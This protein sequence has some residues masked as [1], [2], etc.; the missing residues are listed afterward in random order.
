MVGLLLLGSG[1]TSRAQVVDA[2]EAFV[3]R[4]AE[5]RSARGLGALAFAADLQAVA[6]RHAQR[7][8][9]HGK[10]YHNPALASEVQGWE[11]V[12]ENVGAGMD[13][14]SIHEAFMAS[15]THRDV[16]LHPQLTQLGVGVVHTSDDRLWVVEVF[17]KPAEEPAP[18]E[19]PEPTHD[20]GPAPPPST[21]SSTVPPA[22]STT[23]TPTGATIAPPSTVAVQSAST[24]AARSRTAAAEA[25]RA[26][27]P[28]AVLLNAGA[29]PGVPAPAGLAAFL[30]AA[31]VGLQG[32]AL[33]RLGLVV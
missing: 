22:S 6:R 5:E 10:P 7:M 1:V 8:A 23:T 28:T 12:A 25:V 32:H 27:E 15:S 29:A 4:I 19:E 26:S 21:T 31:V 17:R 24:G 16:I 20:A 18:A 13:V 11:I 3:A 33:R 30:L 2:E 9:D 14:E